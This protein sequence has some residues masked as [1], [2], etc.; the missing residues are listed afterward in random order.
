MKISRGLEDVAEI[1]REATCQHGRQEWVCC[2][3]ELPHTLACVDCGETLRDD[4]GCVIQEPSWFE[5]LL[6]WICRAVNP[7]TGE[8]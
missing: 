1:Y 6:L 5:R 7:R 4:C 8:R 3:G 2:K